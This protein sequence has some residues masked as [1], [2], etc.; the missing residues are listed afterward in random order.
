MK[1]FF[2][3]MPSMVRKGRALLVSILIHASIAMTA[4]SVAYTVKKVSARSEAKMCIALKNYA[5]PKTVTPKEKPKTPKKRPKP[6]P[7]V[8]KTIPVKEPEPIEEEIPEPVVEEVA[9]TEPTEETNATRVAETEPMTTESDS[10]N[11][12]AYTGATYMQEFQSEIVELLQKHLY[13]PRI[14][15]KRGIQGDVTVSFDLSITGEA[16]EIVVVNESHGILN[17]AAITTVE[18][19]LK[20]FPKPPESIRLNVPIHY[21][22]Q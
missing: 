12:V 4:V 15:R 14:A 21:A 1:R 19:A 6:E 10:A 2:R 7:K 16:S 18:R 8:E 13:Y 3:K 17:K 20:S 22:L 9:E 11:Q 5:P